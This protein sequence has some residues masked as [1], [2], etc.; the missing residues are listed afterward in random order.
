MS[1]L[2]SLLERAD[3]AAGRLDLPPDGLERLERHRDRKR[4]NDRIASAALAFVVAAAAIGGAI[5][6][7]RSSGTPRPGEQTERRTITPHRVADLRLAWTA[8]FGQTTATTPVVAGET[9]FVGSWD[10]RLYAFP[11]SCGSAGASCDPLWVGE[12][13]GDPAAPA[14]AGEVVYAG[15]GG[16]LY[17][18]PVSC[19]SGG[20]TCQPLW[21]AETPGAVSS[22]AVGD[23][24]VYVA[25]GDTLYA[26]PTSCGTGGIT[27]EPLWTTRTEGW[28]RNSPTV[29]AGEVYVATDRIVYA[30]PASCGVGST[31]CEPLW[32]GSVKDPPVGTAAVAAGTV[33]VPAGHKIYAF[34]ASCGTGGVMCE[35]LWQTAGSTSSSSAKLTVAAGTVY[36]S[37]NG[38]VNAFPVSCRADGGTCQPV[39]T[40]RARTH[41]WPPAT[42]DGVVYVPSASTLRDGGRSGQ[43][44]AFPASCGAG[45]ATCRPLRTLTLDLDFGIGVAV[46]DGRVFVSSES[47]ASTDAVILQAFELAPRKAPADET[48]SPIYLAI[49]LLLVGSG[50]A[51]LTRRVLRWRRSRLSAPAVS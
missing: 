32:L 37:H 48:S 1:E 18:F 26:F 39:W 2:R 44:I 31:E 5:A 28:I 42:A 27:C 11:T 12:M 45:G 30:F 29:G 20:G 50:A 47:G 9:V 16:K 19:G 35:P 49:W 3:R 46:A 38:E 15:G 24:V 21:T 36:A 43:L 10:N 6:L 7:F 23:G 34:Q 25:A 41:P 14:V 33:L 17:A 40:A 8:R 22:P 4:R 51:V 13:E